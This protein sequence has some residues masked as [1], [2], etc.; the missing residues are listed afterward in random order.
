MHISIP[1]RFFLILG[2][3]SLTL[4][5][6]IDRVCISAAEGPIS[7]ALN[8][9]NKQFGWIMSVFTLGYALFQTPSGMWADKYG[10]RKVLTAIVFIW[11][12][13]TTL[14]GTAFSFIYLIIVRFLFGAG[15]AGAFPSLSKAVFRWYPVKER[16]IVT[17]VN[18]SGSRLG[19]AFALPLVAIM[20]TS[21]G[22]RV[23]FYMLGIVGILWGIFWYLWFRNDPSEKPGISPKELNYILKNRQQ[24]NN[25]GNATF[26]FRDLAR[27]KN[28]WLVMIQYFSSNF[29]FFF[30]LS[31]MFPY[32]EKTYE[33][34]MVDAGLYGS[35]PLICGA[36]GNWA[37]GLLVDFIY[38]KGK[39]KASRYLP[40]I[41]GFS[42]VVFGLLSI[43]HAQ[44]I[45]TAI[46]F[47][48][49]AIFGADMTLSPSW[50]FCIDIGKNN[51]G[52]VSGTM[53]MA[54][55]L[56]SFITV[57]AFPYLYSWTGSNT[58]FFYIAAT[59]GIVAII[60]WL[61]MKPEKGL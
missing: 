16:G 17:G 21:L 43:V 35:I 59:F 22:W 34:T 54:G 60:A 39:L 53:N 52:V 30:C 20:I 33:L 38:R 46:I 47:L 28:M 42:L 27:S 51:A 40:A 8:L 13:F 61:L 36:C 4:L 31:W 1:K 9:S 25:P 57:L 56:G 24:N 7:E 15:E 6:Y 32:L 45:Q 44:N 48:S 19:A 29:I 37:S 26:A 14:T 58:A 55:N 18:F 41:I 2:M 10:P 23:S 12:I 11:S 3:F 49:I 50:S 5:L